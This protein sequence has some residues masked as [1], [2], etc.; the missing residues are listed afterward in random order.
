M[1]IATS[2]SSLPHVYHI[3]IV[4]A[5]YEAVQKR[6]FLPMIILIAT[7]LPLLIGVIVLYR[8]MVE[9][10]NREKERMEMK[11]M[12]KKGTDDYKDSDSEY[13]TESSHLMKMRKE[14]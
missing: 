8:W 9:N 7:H 2:V 5:A 10:P 6:T 12:E 4:D 11:T 1:C 3:Y 13:E 14:K